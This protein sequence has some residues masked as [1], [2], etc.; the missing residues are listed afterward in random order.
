M[1]KATHALSIGT[2]PESDAEDS[3]FSH[4]DLVE[5]ASRE[6]FPASDPPAWEPLH[7]GPP[8][9]PARCDPNDEAAR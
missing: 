9:D 2:R 4:G 1:K 7:S 6:S 5:E 8:A 3:S